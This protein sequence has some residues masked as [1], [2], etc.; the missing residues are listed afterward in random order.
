[1]DK[2]I[3]SENDINFLI[4]WR[5]EHKAMVRQNVCPMKSVEI[6]CKDS[7]FHIKAIRQDEELRLHINHAGR[8]LGHACFKLRYDGLWSLVKDKTKL[9]TK[10]GLQSVVTVY[11]TLMAFMVFG[12][13]E[14]QYED[15]EKEE[16]PVSSPGKKTNKKS[17][18]HKKK[19]QS[20]T[21]ILRSDK[22][23]TRIASKN[24]HASPKGVFGVRGHYRHYK[25]GKVVWI[26][27]FQKGTGKKKSKTIKMGLKE[28]TNAD[29]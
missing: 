2:V 10:D 19:R 16:K 12:N 9:P 22:N 21:Y 13:E 26:S 5:D 29:N 7:G 24:R 23:G 11:G 3:L 4:G 17:N 25:N 14:Y 8:S 18:P 27:E 15:F 20:I 1:M 6:I 28:N